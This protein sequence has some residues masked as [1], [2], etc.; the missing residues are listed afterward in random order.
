MIRTT[1]SFYLASALALSVALLGAFSSAAHAASIVYGNFGPVP[2]GVSFF[3][4]YQ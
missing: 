2:P 1:R 3:L 4:V